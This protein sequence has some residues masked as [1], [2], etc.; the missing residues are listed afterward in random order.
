MAT[1]TT[2]PVRPPRRTGVTGRWIRVAVLAAVAGLV[3]AGVVYW[4]LDPDANPAGPPPATPTAGG[5]VTVIV[6]PPAGPPRIWQVLRAD[7]T[8]L[9]VHGLMGVHDPDLGGHHGMLF[10]FSRPVT[11]TFWMKATPLPLTIAFFDASGAM[12][13]RT[14]TMAPCGDSDACPH[15]A[16]SGPYLYALEAPRG[17]LAPLGLVAGSRIE[18]PDP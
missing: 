11:L 5:L 6:H 1:S 8:P 4:L 18:V 9:I 14:I 16:A 3:V 13:S 15:Y 2:T 17:T 10:E 7:T 12:E